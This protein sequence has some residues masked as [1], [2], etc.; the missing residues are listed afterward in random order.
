MTQF[1]ALPLLATNPDDAT[2]ACACKILMYML[3][4]SVVE[5][6]YS[7]KV[8]NMLDDKPFYYLLTYL[9]ARNI[10]HMGQL[11]H[12]LGGP[13]WTLAHLANPGILQRLELEV[14]Y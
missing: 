12:F 2:A 6:T 9:H 4:I 5:M 14:S 11:F 7:H 8:C 3:G 10:K 13:W 1:L